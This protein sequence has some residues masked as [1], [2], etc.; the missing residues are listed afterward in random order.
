M[1]AISKAAGITPAVIYDHFASKAELQ[2]TLLET[3]IEQLLAFVG[4]ALVAAPSEPQQRLRTGIDAYFRFVEE[5]GYAWR[6]LFRDPPS[7]RKVL[8]TYRRIHERATQGIALFIRTGAP[9][10]FV[11]E[12]GADRAIEM[13]AEIL[14]MALNGLADWWYEHPDVPRDEVVDRMIE[15]CWIGLE[16]VAAGEDSQSPTT[17]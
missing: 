3:E 8:A 14:K 16:R 2:I 17:Q 9:S 4:E 11:G 13:Y 12:P 15:F 6:M 7:D 5:L 10:A 1:A